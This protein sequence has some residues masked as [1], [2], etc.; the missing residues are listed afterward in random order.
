MLKVPHWVII[1][2]AAVLSACTWILSQNTSGQLPLP[3]TWISVIAQVVIIVKA[4]T[5]ILSDSPGVAAKLARAGVRTLSALALL[6]LV[7]CAALKQAVPGI[8]NVANAVCQQLDS[9]PEPAWVYFVCGIE[10]P[11][12][13]IVQTLIAVPANKAAEFKA[14]HHAELPS[15]ARRVQ[16]GSAEARAVGF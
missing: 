4:A 10:G 6:V 7:A 14:S 1:A 8:V 5:G 12:G 2:C 11:A 15:Y 3:A 16:I 13:V 9:Q